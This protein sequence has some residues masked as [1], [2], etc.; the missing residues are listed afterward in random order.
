MAQISTL[1]TLRTQP[2][3]SEQQRISDLQQQ[4]QQQAQQDPAGFRTAMRSAF[5]DKASLA[6]IDQLLDLAL[7]GKLPMPSTIQF[8]EAGSLGSG[9][10]GAYDASNG[11]S[12]YLDRSLLSDPSM[13]QSVFNEEMGHHLDGLLGGVDA[14]GDEGAVFSRTLEQGTFVVSR[15]IP[16][17]FSQIKA[18]C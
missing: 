9:A 3:A 18:H 5:G 7:A 6:Q 16:A 12:L 17:A 11:G 4:F 13:L 14:A 10:L 8:V 2:T 1:E 15:I